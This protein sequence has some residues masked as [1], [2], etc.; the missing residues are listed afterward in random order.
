MPSMRVILPDSSRLGRSG[1]RSSSAALAC[2][3]VL[4]DLL[5]EA[6]SKTGLAKCRPRALAAQP[7]WVSRICPTFMREG[8]PRGL[9]TISTARPVR[10]VRHVLVGQDAGDH[11]LVA[12]AARPSCRPPT[13]L[14]L[15]GHEDLDQLDHAGGQL[16]PPLQPALLLREQRLQDLDLA[17]GL[18]HDLVELLLHLVLVAPFTR[19]FRMSEWRSFCE[20]VP[21]ELLAL[22]DDLVAAG[23]DEVGRR[24]SCRPGGPRSACR[25]RPGGCGSRPSGSSPS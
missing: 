11:A 3:Q 2:C 12:V 19:S 6:P 22:L 1:F 5:L 14:A 18:V 17:L 7:R 25:A 20:H 24:R 21:G 15:H 10:E 23:V 13:E 4:L 9:S 16:V 8:T